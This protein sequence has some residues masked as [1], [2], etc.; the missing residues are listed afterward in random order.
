[1]IVDA[2]LRPYAA[3][4]MECYPVSAAV[5]NAR[6]ETPACVERVEISAPAARVDPQLLLF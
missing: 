4:E 5:N 3:A 1:M 6:N 2:L